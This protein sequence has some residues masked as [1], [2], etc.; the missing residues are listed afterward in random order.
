[1]I[2]VEIGRVQ[3]RAFVGDL[4]EVRTV[5]DHRRQSERKVESRRE[6]KRKGRDKRQKESNTGTKTN[7]AKKQYTC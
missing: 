2:L 4:L 5:V 3:R 1:L 7:K 6:E